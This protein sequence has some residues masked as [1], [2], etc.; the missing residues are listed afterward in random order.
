ML[1]NLNETIQFL[2]QSFKTYTGNNPIWFLYPVALVLIWFLGKKEDRKLFIGVLVTECLTIFN[3]FIVKILLD[4]FGFGSRFVRF[5]WILVFFITIAYALT[6]L[7]FASGK[8]WVKIVTGGICAALIVAVGIPV[9]KGAEG[10]PY[11]KATNEYFIDQEILDLSNII[12]SEG[13]EQPRI[14]SDGLLLLYRQYDPDVESYVSRRIL[15]KIEKSSEEKFMKKKKIKD[16]MKKIIAVYYYHDYELE[17]EE[18][19]HL[20]EI[21]KIDY[22]ISTSQELDEYLAGTTMN[23]IGQTGNCRVWK[24]V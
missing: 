3:P 13:L 22:I 21:S 10:F 24:V 19:Q 14:L 11:A 1:E 5:L 9:F 20:A 6:L 15:Q 18:F 7:I 17:A 16:W 12:H 8:I 2:L 4:V 23:V